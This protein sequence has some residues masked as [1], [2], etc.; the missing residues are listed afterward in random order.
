MP[1]AKFSPKESGRS[2]VVGDAV[3]INKCDSDT[4]M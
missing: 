4:N 3:A 1:A 2:L